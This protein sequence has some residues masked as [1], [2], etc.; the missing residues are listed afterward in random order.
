MDTQ[1][2]ANVNNYLEFKIYQETLLW[3]NRNI[4]YLQRE[5]TAEHRVTVEIC[6][7]S[8]KI[9]SENRVFYN[10]VQQ[11]NRDISLSVLSTFWKLCQNE[12]E[13]RKSGKKV[14]GNDFSVTI[15]K[16]Y[17]STTHINVP[18]LICDQ[19]FIKSK[20]S[21]LRVLEALSATGLRS[22]RY[23]NEVP[24]IK[25]IIANDLS[26]AAV[27]SIREN[28]K[29]NKVEHLVK[30]SEANAT[31]LMY[32]SASTENRFDAIDLGRNNETKIHSHYSTAHSKL[33]LFQIHMGIRRCFWTVLYKV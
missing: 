18:V 20:Q 12:N 30:A 28:I 26:S 17:F 22:I 31:T 8:A 16:E 33:S 6:E 11:F 32:N 7:G 23:A 5:T 4:S 3:P 27:K 19:Y 2:D 10:P 24:G 15:S 9:V 14:P 29:L 21:G 25:E 1:T 13:Q